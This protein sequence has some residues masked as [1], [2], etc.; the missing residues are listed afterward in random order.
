MMDGLLLTACA[1][2]RLPPAV[3][4]PIIYRTSALPRRS[5]F[6][7]RTFWVYQIRCTLK[8]IESSTMIDPGQQ[9]IDSLQELFT[10]LSSDV[11][12]LLPYIPR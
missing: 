8:S 2:Y 7:R 11:L 12:V 6:G 1:V 10:F 9:S 3:H 4:R 5:M